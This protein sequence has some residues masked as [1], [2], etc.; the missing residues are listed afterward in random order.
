MLEETGRLTHLVDSL[1]LLTRANH[2]QIPLIREKIDPVPLIEKAVDDLR[3]MAEEKG[4]KIV[5]RPAQPGANR[6]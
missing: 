1:L 6:D 5:S 2:E 3:V 4:Q